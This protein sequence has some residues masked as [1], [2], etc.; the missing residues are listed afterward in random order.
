MQKSSSRKSLTL[1][2]SSQ[3][4]V[5]PRRRF[6]TKKELEQSVNRLHRGDSVNV[7]YKYKNTRAQGTFRNR[8]SFHKNL[9]S[10]FKVFTP[11]CDRVRRLTCVGD[12]FAEQTKAV[13]KN[14]K[15]QCRCS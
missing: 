14:Q 2:K 4:L 15:V 9:P 1:Q 5:T 10:G 3:G 13:C 12:S 8:L 7:E 11:K 6:K